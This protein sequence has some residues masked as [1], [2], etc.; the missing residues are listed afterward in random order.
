[1]ALASQTDAG[2]VVA[3]GCCSLPISSIHGRSQALQM[4][5]AHMRAVHDLQ[6]ERR[7]NAK[8]GALGVPVYD[9]MSNIKRSQEPNVSNRHYLEGYAAPR[10]PFCVSSLACL[11]ATPL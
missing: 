4:P 7:A 9:L 5:V 11:A 8:R 3:T 1:M 10:T 6:H 2:G